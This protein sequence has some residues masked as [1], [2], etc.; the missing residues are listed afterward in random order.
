MESVFHYLFQK[1]L[2][3]IPVQSHMNP[4]NSLQTHTFT[5]SFNKPNVLRLHWGLPTCLFEVFESNFCTHFFI[6]SMLSTY[7]IRLLPLDLIA[8]KTKAASQANKITNREYE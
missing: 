4:I 1:T 5:I 8:L 7:L 3:F 2:P 6:I